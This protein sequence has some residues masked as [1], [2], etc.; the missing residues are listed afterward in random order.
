VPSLVTETTPDNKPLLGDVAGSACLST[1][2]LPA[3]LQRGEKQCNDGS[4]RS[5]GSLPAG[6]RTRYS[7]RHSIRER[8]ALFPA[9]RVRGRSVSFIPFRRRHTL[10]SNHVPS[11]LIG[12]RA[13]KARC[14]G[15]C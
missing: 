15:H 11:P 8:T 3:H 12:D 14:L 13:Q 1:L 5:C 9:T 7:R 4:P 2:D 6:K 10:N